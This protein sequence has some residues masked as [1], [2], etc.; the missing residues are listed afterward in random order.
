MRAPKN[1]TRALNNETK[2]EDIL[3]QKIKI[4]KFKNE[5]IDPKCE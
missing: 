2:V 3:K 5:Q 4:W 1:E